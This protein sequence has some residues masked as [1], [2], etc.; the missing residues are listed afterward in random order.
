MMEQAVL[1]TLY[2]YDYATVIDFTSDADSYSSRLLPVN[3]EN[4]CELENYIDSFTA[5][6]GTNY[7]SAFEK[8][9]EI[10]AASMTSGHVSGCNAQ[11]ILFLT[12][13]QITSGRDDIVD[14][15]EELK[16]EPDL[17]SKIS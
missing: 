3:D 14:Y 11:I 6:G 17:L 2:K 10:M 4:R 12:D 15:I 16:D 13:G 1:D 5:F 8:A 9:Y 7:E